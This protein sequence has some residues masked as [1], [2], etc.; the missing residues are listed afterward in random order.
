MKFKYVACL[1]C[2]L[3][4]AAA[5]DSIP[6]P[7]AIYPRNNSS[8]ALSALSIHGHSTLP[9]KERFIGPSS[10]RLI[11]I[12]WLSFRLGIDNKYVGFRFLALIRCSADASPPIFS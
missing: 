7:P 8:C 4:F 6:D 2:L 3:L 9:G 1:L 5:I 11:K 10:P 12:N